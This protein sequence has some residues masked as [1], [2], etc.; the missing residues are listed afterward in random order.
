[1][2]IIR[3]ND[4]AQSM[5]S[6]AFTTT[7]T[8]ATPGLHDPFPSESGPP[9]RSALDSRVLFAGGS[10]IVIF[11]YGEPYRLRETRQGKL[12]LTK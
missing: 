3:I 6:N 9:V 12:I 5:K 1:M 10:E 11:H 2:R 4:V 7:R 8:T